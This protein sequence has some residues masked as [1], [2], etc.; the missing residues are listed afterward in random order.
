MTL[1]ILLDVDG[2][3]ADFASQFCE[4]YYMLH[5]E[6]RHPEHITTF[7]M[8]SLG[9]KHKVDECWRFIRRTYGVVSSLPEYPGAY[10]ALK[11][12]RKM[13]RVI[14]C[15]SPLDEAHNWPGERYAWLRARGFH[16]RDIVMAADKS[17]IQGDV[18][19][20]DGIHNLAEWEVRPPA[21]GLKYLI[22]RPWNTAGYSGAYRCSLATVVAD[23]KGELA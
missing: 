20:D 5:H 4:I 16:H 19:I 15:T 3:L 23:L 8:S 6:S 13:G 9:P 14:A 7:D 18:L 1:T 11:E 12:L 10:G 17:T 21:L 2:V 22:S